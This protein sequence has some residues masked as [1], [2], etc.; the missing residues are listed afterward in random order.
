MV[1]IT[2]KKILIISICIIVFIIAVLGVSGKFSSKKTTYMYYDNF[3]TPSIKIDYVY[4][5]DKIIKQD[6]T[7]ST[8]YTSLKASKESLKKTYKGLSEKYKNIEGVKTSINYEQSVILEK[9]E[10]NYNKIS[11]KALKN[12]HAPIQNGGLPANK[13]VSLEK[14]IKELKQH[15]FIDSKTYFK[16]KND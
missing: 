12:Y 2:L 7:I 13:P 11:S 4:R 9:I 6:T 8:S 3:K 10:V 15:N 14:S 5:G 1:K 16:S